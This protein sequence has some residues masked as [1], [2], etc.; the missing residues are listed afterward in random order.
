AA[1]VSSSGCANTASKQRRAD[2]LMRIVS[3][4][5]R[6]RR[7]GCLGQ[8]PSGVSPSTGD[9]AVLAPCGGCN[10]PR[11]PGTL[12]LRVPPP[13]A[14]HTARCMPASAGRSTACTGEE[15]LV[16]ARPVRLP[17]LSAMDIAQ[18]RHALHHPCASA[19]R[20]R[21][22]GGRS[23]NGSRYRSGRFRA[24]ARPG[25]GGGGPARGGG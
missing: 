15:A 13:S 4:L 14:A 8:A 3:P 17:G 21:E 23:S 1:E 16:G 9:L 5:D 2:W 12:L 18:E 7:V 6:Q 11:T 20:A 25:D 10:V 24:T 19:A 22:S